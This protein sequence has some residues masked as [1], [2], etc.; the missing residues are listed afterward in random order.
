MAENR[1][2]GSTGGLIAAAGH[3]R[4]LRAVPHPDAGLVG[5]GHCGCLFQ[6]GQES[7]LTG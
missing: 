5:R 4:Q 2:C 3:Q 1:A 7:K 6:Q